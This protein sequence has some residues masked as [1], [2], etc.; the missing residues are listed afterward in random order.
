MK[1][2]ILVCGVGGQGTVLASKLLAQAALRL[3]QPVKT[4]ETIGMAQRGGSVTSHVR[5][6]QA[7]SPLIPRGQADILLCF[8]PGEAVRNLPYLRRGGLLIVA[9]NPVMPVTAALGLRY[10]PQAALDYLKAN[11]PG[12]LDVDAEACCRQLNSY[13]VKNTVLLGVLAGSGRCCLPEEALRE[14]LADLPVK[15][16][17]LN[18]DAFELGLRLAQKV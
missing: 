11:V 3:G 1:Q 17:K 10:D 9:Q 2:S 4:C 14:A 8:E 7:H 15:Y 18:L 12:V 13:R 6:G 16:R 5:I